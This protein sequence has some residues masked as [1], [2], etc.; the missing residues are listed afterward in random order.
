MPIKGDYIRPTDL[1]AN[2]ELK[3]PMHRIHSMITHC[4]PK[5]RTKKVAKLG[6]PYFKGE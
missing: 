6:T 2:F 3:Q 5:T 4:T 1:H